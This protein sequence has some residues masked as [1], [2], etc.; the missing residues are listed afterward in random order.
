MTEFAIGNFLLFVKSKIV[1]VGMSKRSP[2]IVDILAFCEQDTKNWLEFFKCSKSSREYQLSIIF[3]KYT[4]NKPN[5]MCIRTYL[6]YDFGFKKCSTCK[7]IK[8]LDLYAARS[9][10]FKKLHEECKECQ[11]NWSRTHKHIRNQHGA[12][13]RAKLINAQPKWLSEEQQS[14]IK[15][16]YKEAQDKTKIDG[17]IY[18]VDHIVPLQGK[19]VCGLHVPWNLQVI[20]A[21]ENLRKS[22]NYGL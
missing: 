16:L 21:E 11:T 9:R 14:T 1:A 17:I 19:N 4:Q 8:S 18:H 15:Q 7:T 3:G 22:N 5:S 12:S 13:R 20:T 2:K 6:L 10:G